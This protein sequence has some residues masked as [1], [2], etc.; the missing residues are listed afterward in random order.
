MQCVGTADL[1][2][3][4]GGITV[5][6]AARTEDPHAERRCQTPDLAPDAARADDAGRLA[7]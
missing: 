6:A 1:L 2:E 4:R 3:P 7:G 5:G